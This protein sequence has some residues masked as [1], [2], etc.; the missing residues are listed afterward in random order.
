M[1]PEEVIIREQDILTRNVVDMH[2][3]GL[4]QIC[5][6][7]LQASHVLGPSRASRQHAGKVTT[8]QEEWPT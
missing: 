2:L 3:D 7:K 4:G 5:G 8:P 1:V 6:S